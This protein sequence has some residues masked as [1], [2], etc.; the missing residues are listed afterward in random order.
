MVHQEMLEAHSD[1][2][3]A[4]TNNLAT[5]EEPLS[6]ENKRRNTPVG[7]K[8][9]LYPKRDCWRITH[10]ALKTICS[11][12]PTDPSEKRL[13]AY[14]LAWVMHLSTHCI[15]RVGFSRSAADS[16][17]S[18]RSPRPLKPRTSARSPCAAG[19][20][21]LPPQS[22]PETNRGERP[23]GPYLRYSVIPRTKMFPRYRVT[24]AAWYWV[25]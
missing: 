1:H 11:Y 12:V 18:S 13:R 16:S 9:P 3:M 19:H 24:H 23:T 4:G 14:G 25:L 10:I 6:R 7:A 2:L 5:M 22:P 15:I 8:A 17:H 21:P 20:G